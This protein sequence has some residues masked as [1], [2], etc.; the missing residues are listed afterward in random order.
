VVSWQTQDEHG[1][2]PLLPLTLAPSGLAVVTSDETSFRRGFLD[3]AGL[4][5]VIADGK[6]GSGLTNNPT[7]CCSLIPMAA[8]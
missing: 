2:D 1:A 3:F 5:V 6:V 7:T 4:L 8:R